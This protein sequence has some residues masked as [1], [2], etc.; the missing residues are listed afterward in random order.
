MEDQSRANF[1]HALKWGL[2]L[3]M[4][5]IILN[6]IVYI[7]DKSIL[8]S[9]W[10]GGITFII[11]ITLM[12]VPVTQRRKELG[13]FIDFK[14][15]F[16]ICFV[17]IAGGALLQNVYNYF[18]YNMIDQGLAE[19]IKQKSIESATSMMEKFGTPQ[20]AMDKAIE[21]IQN[22]DFNQTPAR[23]GKQYFLMLIFGGVI[24]SIIAA[25]FRKSPK[26]T[27]I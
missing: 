5:D 25:I 20:E 27:D 8:T 24:A 12:I 9:M 19:Y 22:T 1:E 26:T 4:T 2:I 10:F 23:I 7:I 18:L 11:N 13:G 15:A 16:L 6:L 17:V 14:D 3:G 21:D